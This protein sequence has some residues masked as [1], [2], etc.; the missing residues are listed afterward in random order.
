M[1]NQAKIHIVRDDGPPPGWLISVDLD[2]MERLVAITPYQRYAHVIAE[3]LSQSTD[4]HLRKL[5]VP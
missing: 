1:T 3:A 4:D 5:E 2:G